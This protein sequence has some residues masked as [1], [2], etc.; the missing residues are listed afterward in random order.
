MSNRYTVHISKLVLSSVLS[1]HGCLTDLW[2]KSFYAFKNAPVSILKLLSLHPCV[3]DL[4]FPNE[5]CRFLT[6]AP[7]FRKLR[8]SQISFTDC[9]QLLKKWR[10]ILCALFQWKNSR[11]GRTAEDPSEPGGLITFY[12]SS[13][14]LVVRVV[15]SDNSNG[16]ILVQPQF[17]YHN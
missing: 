4:L 3:S 10:V 1:K 15:F 2:L 9:C 5:T 8:I 12:L 16:V 6:T 13:A 14:K 11:S 7:S 17:G